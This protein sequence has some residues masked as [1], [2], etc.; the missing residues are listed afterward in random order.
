MLLSRREARRRL[1]ARWH[2]AVAELPAGRE[3][4]F[5]L[6][7]FVTEENIA[8]VRRLN[9]YAGYGESDERRRDRELVAAWCQKDNGGPRQ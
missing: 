2:S 9:L 1:V 3:P 5:P 7:H 4:L 8:V 6:E